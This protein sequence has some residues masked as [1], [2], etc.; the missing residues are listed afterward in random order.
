MHPLLL[1]LFLL[2]WNLILFFCGPRPWSLSPLL[3]AVV[4]LLASVLAALFISFIL[5]FM[6]TAVLHLLIAVL[7]TVLIVM[8]IPVFRFI[9]GVKLFPVPTTNLHTQRYTAVLVSMRKGKHVHDAVLMLGN[10]PRIP[11]GTNAC[12]SM[13]SE[14]KTPNSCSGFNWQFVLGCDISPSIKVMLI[15]G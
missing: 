10:M 14:N 11:A 5:F 2:V 4:S 6:L 13:H 8:V 15:H 1:T 3:T 9:W 7:I 12:H